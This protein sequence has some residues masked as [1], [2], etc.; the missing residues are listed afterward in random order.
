MSFFLGVVLEELQYS[1]S[2]TISDEDIIESYDSAA[3]NYLKL[4]LAGDSKSSL[5][6]SP[7]TSTTAPEYSSIGQP[8]EVAFQ[9]SSILSVRQG[10][11][12]Y[13]LYLFQTLFWCWYT[14]KLI[15]I[16]TK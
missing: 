15:I 10:Y 12:Y 13:I 1:S 14:F 2:N 8:L 4:L 9:R 11:I 6:R 16:K 5:P 3:N 7:S